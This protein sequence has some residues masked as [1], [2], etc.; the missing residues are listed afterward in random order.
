MHDMQ[1]MGAALLSVAIPFRPSRILLGKLMTEETGGLRD[2]GSQTDDH[3][4]C[5]LL[6]LYTNI[7]GTSELLILTVANAS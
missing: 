5:T 2:M 4:E 7:L 6:L 3:R 1:E